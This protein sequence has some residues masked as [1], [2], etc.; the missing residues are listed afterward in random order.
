MLSISQA[1]MQAGLR[2]SFNM[3]IVAFKLFGDY[4]HFSHPETRYSSLTYPVPPK[5]TIM[6]LL[7]AIIGEDDFWNLSG[8]RY[9][10]KID[11]PIEKRTFCFNGIAQAQAGSIKLE[12]GYQNASLK[13]QFYRELICSPSYTIYLELDEVDVKY[14]E[15]IK[16]N[17]KEHK[18]A[19]TP[20]LGINFCLANF[21][22]INITSCEKVIGYEALTKCAIPLSNYVVDCSNY[23]QKLSTFRGAKSVEKGRY[24]KDFDDFIIEVNGACP[25]KAKNNNN[26]CK[27]NGENVF[28]F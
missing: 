27:V 25:L 28:F 19:Y 17:L 15:L 9:A 22:W 11:K 21:E 1:M 14:K 10:V 7:G 13:K 12:E 8:L 26:M 23:K 18:T 5:T 4:A 20:F 16:N 6:G 24:Y 2:K 3:D